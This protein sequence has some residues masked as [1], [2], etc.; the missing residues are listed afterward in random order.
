VVIVCLYIARIDP[1]LSLEEQDV[2]LTLDAVLI[3]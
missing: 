3:E 2:N 1:P